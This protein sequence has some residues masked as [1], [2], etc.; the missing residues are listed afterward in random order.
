MKKISWFVDAGVAG[1]QNYMHGEI[2]VDKNATE[3]EINEIV[4]ED[5]IQNLNWGWGEVKKD[6]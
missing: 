6:A 5:I 4:F 2:E 3:E 1:S